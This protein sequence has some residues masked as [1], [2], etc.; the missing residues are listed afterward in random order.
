M[1][2]LAKCCSMKDHWEYIG[3]PPL[4]WELL[5]ML[6]VDVMGGINGG[7]NDTVVPIFKDIDAMVLHLFTW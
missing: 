2:E 4:Q 5:P 3:V 6:V 1:F 7:P